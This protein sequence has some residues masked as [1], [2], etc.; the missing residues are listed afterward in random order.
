MSERTEGW[1]ITD[2][3]RHAVARLDDA[4]LRRYI[5]AYE[6]GNVVTGTCRACAVA[7]MTGGHYEEYR[8]EVLRVQQASR[9]MIDRQGADAHPLVIIEAVFEWYPFNDERKRI[10]YDA[11]VEEL[12]ARNAE[13]VES[14]ERRTP[15]LT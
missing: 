8:D 14:E 10:V 13:H 11:C 2:W 9:E 4:Q 5:D 12:T 6:A 7:H 15:A 1:D 3:A